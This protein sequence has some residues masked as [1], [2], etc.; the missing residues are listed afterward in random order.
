MHYQ[1]FGKIARANKIRMEG[2]PDTFPTLGTEIQSAK[3]LRKEQ[4]ATIIKARCEYWSAIV[5]RPEA[6][7]EVEQAL[8]NAGDQGARIVPWTYGLSPF[9][10]GS[11]YHMLNIFIHPSGNRDTS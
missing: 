1:D 8:V 5:K 7:N 11:R 9:L 3:H 2:W 4:I 10:F 6:R